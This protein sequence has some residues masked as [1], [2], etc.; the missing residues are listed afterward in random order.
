MGSYRSKWD[1][2]A[3]KGAVRVMETLQS[4]RTEYISR[5]PHPEV[6]LA[7]SI[8]AIEGGWPWRI[9]RSAASC[10]VYVDVRTLPSQPL[11]PVMR[12]LRELVRSVDPSDKSYRSEVDF[13]ATI[14]GSEVNPEEEIVQAVK[15][16]HKAVHG[17]EPGVRFSQAT[18]DAAHFRRYG[19]PTLI[20]G[21]GGAR[22]PDN[23]E[24][25]GE[26]VRIDNLVNCTKVYA[27]TALELC[28]IQ[29]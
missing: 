8:S 27:L 22:M 26:C 14:S 4:W 7:V 9:S 28:N 5:Y 3:I 18:N 11:V 12:E 17:E 19:I 10:S 16:A 15:R 23:A 2:S 25:L 29:G 13:Y 21:P 6:Q 24:E 20:Y 1:D